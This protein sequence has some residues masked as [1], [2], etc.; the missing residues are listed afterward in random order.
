MNADSPGNSNGVLYLI[1][2]GDEAY[3]SWSDVIF[4]KLVER[5][6]GGKFAV[7][8]Y[9]EADDWMCNYLKYLGAK[10]AFHVIIPDRKAA[11][12]LH[13]C[14]EMLNADALFIE[15]GHQQLYV[16][17]IA[18]TC[19]EQMIF[20]MYRQEK[21]LAG[22]SA[23]AM[24][25]GE[26]SFLSYAGR[27][28]P[29]ALFHDPFMS[30]ISLHDSFLGLVPNTLIDTHFSERGRLPRLLM[31]MARYYAETS[32]KITG[33]GIDEGTVLE[34]DA[35]MQAYIIGN[36][37]VTLLVPDEYTRFLCTES[38]PPQML[39]LRLHQLSAGACWDLKSEYSYDD[40]R[41]ESIPIDGI[42]GGTVDEMRARSGAMD[43]AHQWR[44][45]MVVRDLY[46]NP[47]SAAMQMNDMLRAL[48]LGEKH[49]GI[50][51]ASEGIMEIVGNN[52]LTFGGA[53]PSL[54]FVSQ[55]GKRIGIESA[56]ADAVGKQSLL[57]ARVHCL[58]DEFAYL[59]DHHEV[60]PIGQ[61]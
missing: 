49:A 46:K 43:E 41:V 58:H 31:L 40:N 9:D 36:G 10:D 45:I 29:E 53:V 25:L 13:V 26:I 35:Q 56:A 51:V 16:E 38:K 33:I 50:L 4:K 28:H 32:R 18:G 21:V 48:A 44:D 11:N 17:N 30:N 1:G 39:N 42:Q 14:R 12:N 37:K 8:Y 52:R 27:I 5:A 60:I 23:G 7:L 6:N 55:Q 61:A 59:L 20:E 22:T 47:C 2:G 34:I 15:G 57:N 3:N 24:L 54:V 19:A